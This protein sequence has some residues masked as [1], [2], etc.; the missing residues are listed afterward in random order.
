LRFLLSLSKQFVRTLAVVFL[1]SVASSVMVR[2]APGYLSDTRE[3]DA[4]YASSARH[5]L[6]TEATRNGS[7]NQVLMNQVSD[8]TRGTLG[9]SREYE[10][11]V[12]ELLRPRLAVTGS[13]ALRT[14]GFAW[15]LAL[16][17]AL[18]AS[19][20]PRIR[21]ASQIPIALLL[22]VP[23]AAMATTCL[24]IDAGGPVIVLTLVIAVRDFKFV[25]RILRKAWCEPHLLQARA[26]G[27]TTAR[28]LRAHII[29]GIAPQLLALASLSIVTA[30]GAIVPVEVIF[31]V[32]GLGSLAWGAA[33]N[34]DIP[35]LVAVTML[36]A[37]T[38]TLCEFI[39]NRGS[40]LVSV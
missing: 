8:W 28:M 20:A 2:L 26:Q 39:S 1:V 11:P 9:L 19:L 34:R 40:E 4:K 32:P 35:V 38:V 33:Q 30:L 16:C 29:P 36:F 10:I 13:L 17:G 18:A 25:E 7:I 12:L 3:M 15:T 14:I 27:V 24:L 21:L 37:V 22:A 5:E 23:T 6:V 31:S